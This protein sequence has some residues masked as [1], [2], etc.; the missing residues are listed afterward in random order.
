MFAIFMEFLFT[1][2]NRPRSIQFNPLLSPVKIFFG[3]HTIP[4]SIKCSLTCSFIKYKNLIIFFTVLQILLFSSGTVEVNAG[5]DK[6][7]KTNLSFAVWILDSIPARDFARIPLIE[8]LQATYDFDIFGVC[9]SFLNND[10]SNEDIL[11]RG[12]SPDPFRADKPVNTRNGGVCLY[13]KEKLPIKERI[14]LEIIIPETI[15]AEVKLNRKKIFFVLSYCHPNLSSAEYDVYVK[16]LEQL[17][18]RI[19]K[20]NTAVTILTGDF[21]AW[22]PLFWKG[23]METRERRILSNFLLSNNV[24]ELINEPTH[25][26]DDGSQ[27]CLDLVCTDQPY[28][29]TDTGVMPSLDP[30]SKHNVIHGSLNFHITCPP[31]YKR[32]VWDYKT[33]KTNMI[34]QELS[35]TN[36]HSLFLGLNASEMSLVFT[37]VLL[38]IFSRHISNKIITCNDKD[39]PWITPQVKSTIRRNSGVYR[40]WVQRGRVPGER[41]KVREVQNSTNKLIN[42]AK[43]TYYENLGN[44]LSDPDTGPKYFWTAFKRISNKKKQTNIPPIFENNCYVTNFQQKAQ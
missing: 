6:S 15:V 24:E 39:A 4:R 3:L 42:E 17:Y 9:E 26:R 34:R 19:N 38:N 31:P 23:D 5:P 2:V 41:D 36:W 7:K 13:F 22:S 29:F 14:D 27:S 20:E 28:I 12:F 21:N 8:T 44:K 11:I 43:R 18:E 40:K 30:H 33:A 35:S 32:K 16:S 25:I 10:V 1:S 37:D